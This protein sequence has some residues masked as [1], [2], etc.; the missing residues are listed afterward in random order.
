MEAV[1]RFGFSYSFPVETTFLL[2]NPST[3]P[4]S[5]LSNL[6]EE[7]KQAIIINKKIKPVASMAN[8]SGKQASAVDGIKE[9]LPVNESAVNP[10]FFGNITIING[11]L[12]FQGMVQ[13]IESIWINEQKLV[14]RD[15][16]KF[17]GKFEIKDGFTNIRISTQK[18]EEALF[19]RVK[20]VKNKVYVYGKTKLLEKK[21]FINNQPVKYK[22]ISKFD[23]TLEFADKVKM[24]LQIG[25]GN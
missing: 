8:V 7:Q 1:H 13:D 23:K 20:V 21:I 15:D 14:I 9:L 25:L 18:E 16:Q 11:K 6:E 17:Y 3:Y 4:E 10:S 2:E 24:F 22:E 19:I 5:I 12:V